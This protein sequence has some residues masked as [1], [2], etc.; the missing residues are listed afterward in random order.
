[1]SISGNGLYLIF[2]IAHPDMH[3]AQFDA[4]VRE[5]YEKTG[6]VADQRVLRM[7]A[8]CGGAS[9]DAYPYIQ[10]AR[11][12]LSGRVKEKPQGPKSGRPGKSCSMK[13]SIN[14]IKKIREEKKD[15]TDDYHDWYCIGCALA[16]E[17]GKEEGAAA[18]SSGQHALQEVLPDRLRRAVRQMSAEPENRDRDSFLW[19]C[20]KHGV[21][22]K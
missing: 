5:I 10:S 17:Y 7:S 18:I 13:R 4:L 19:I 16:H 21:T 3:L 1:M 6:L 12:A 15:I 9:Y 11:E 20:K 14:L 22:F 8:A 2:R